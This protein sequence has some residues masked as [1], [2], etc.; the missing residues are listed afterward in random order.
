MLADVDKPELPNDSSNDSEFDIEEELDGP[1]V[2]W[3]YI[4]YK[5]NSKKWKWSWWW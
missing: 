4:E 2:R 1:E 5:S 3:R